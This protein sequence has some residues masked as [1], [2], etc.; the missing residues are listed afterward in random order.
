MDIELKSQTTYYTILL[1][2]FSQNNSISLKSFLKKPAFKKSWGKCSFRS[3]ATKF[4]NKYCFNEANLENKAQHLKYFKNNILN[5]FQSCSNFFKDEIETRARRSRERSEDGIRNCYE[6]ETRSTKK[7][8]KSLKS[9]I[10]VF[11]KLLYFK[12]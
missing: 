7:K 10:F 11:C 6:N 5:N 12:N 9:L 2:N 4:A 1:N 8:C 3:I